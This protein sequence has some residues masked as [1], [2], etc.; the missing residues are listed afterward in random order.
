M[1][2]LI[3]IDSISK[4]QSGNGKNISLKKALSENGKGRNHLIRI[5]KRFSS[6]DLNDNWPDWDQ[7]SDYGR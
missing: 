3:N 2:D 7:W 6:G 1:N 5:I 4:K